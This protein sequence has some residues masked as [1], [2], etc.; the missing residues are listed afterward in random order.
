MIRGGEPSNKSRSRLPRALE[1]GAVP[2]DI[3]RSRLNVSLSRLAPFVDHFR[4]V[5]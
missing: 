4:L 5:K 2:L 1:L 3:E